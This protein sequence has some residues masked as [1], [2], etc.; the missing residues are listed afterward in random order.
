[1]SRDKWILESTVTRRS[2]EIRD[3]RPG[4]LNPFQGCLRA[5][6]NALSE[7]DLYLTY[8]QLQ[9]EYR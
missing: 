7:R 1:M 2:P 5:L 6:H 8:M 4:I 9:E 3:L